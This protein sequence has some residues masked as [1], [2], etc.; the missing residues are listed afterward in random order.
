MINNPSEFDSGGDDFCLH[1][2]VLTSV[3]NLIADLL[4]VRYTEIMLE[5]AS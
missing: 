4:I 2:E 3:W 5:L 1:R